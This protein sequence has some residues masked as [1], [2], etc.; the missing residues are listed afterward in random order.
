[1][2]YLAPSRS[3]HGTNL[4]DGE[5]GEV[6]VQ[7]EPLGGLVLFQSVEYLVVHTHHAER[8]H[9]E[10]LRLAAGKERGAVHSRKNARLAG[11][12]PELV[13]PAAVSPGSFVD[14]ERTH[15]LLHHFV[16]ES[17]DIVAALRVLRLKMLLQLVSGC[18]YRVAAGFFLV[19]FHRVA[20]LSGKV[21]RRPCVDV[22]EGG[23]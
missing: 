6:I 12:L 2:P 20:D 16:D 5:R 10:R 18:G 23:S 14:D 17:C 9:N 7:N 22:G 19:N 21:L 11:D 1:V 3:S 15:R 4:S 8:R 13:H